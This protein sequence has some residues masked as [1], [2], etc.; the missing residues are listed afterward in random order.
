MEP[1]QAGSR[2][3]EALKHLSPG[4]SI[5]VAYHP[6]F[7]PYDDLV[8]LEIDEKLLPDVLCERVVLRGQPDED[9]VLCTQS[10]TYAIKFVGTSNSVL[11]IPPRNQS[12]FYENPQK[13]D[14]NN[15]DDEEKV[16][17]PVIKVAPGNM[18]LVEVAPRLDKLKLLL[19]EKPYSFEEY[20]MGNLKEN[21][22]SRVGLYNWNDLIDNI[23]ASD[24]ELR[25]ALQALSA[26]EINGYWRLVS[27]SYMDMILG[28]L[29][30]NSVLNDWSLAALN[31]DEVVSTLE[32]DGF[33]VVLAR[34]CLHVYGKKVNDRIGSCVW[35]LDEKWVCIHFA[36]EILRGGKRK[37]ESFMDEWKQ[38]TPDG[39]QPT[40]DFVE[41]EVLTERV[42][43]ETWVYAFSVSSLPSSPAERFSILFRER[44][45][46]EW[47]DLQPYIRDLNIPGLSSEGLLLK[48][49]RRTQP[50][51]DTEP[52]FSAR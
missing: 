41:G 19:S 50:S 21:Q 10:K 3:A 43:V 15:D 26:L 36:R 23:Q 39:M 25:S 48:Y 29:L 44:P 22:E 35:K 11:L 12:E 6:L 49:T 17:A 47:K 30:K 45:K 9:A 32:S 31:E 37:L 14:N 16:V 4:S 51:P 24:E 5:S 52:V 38:K 33:P 27:E 34:H 28:M 8:L 42:G 20:D 7:G 2:G 1:P 18:E 46:W 13:N 40:F